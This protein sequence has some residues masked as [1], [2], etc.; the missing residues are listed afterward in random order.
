MKRLK[1]NV[2]FGILWM[3]A[4][5]ATIDWVGLTILIGLEKNLFQTKPAPLT[6][7]I[8]ATEFERKMKEKE[9]VSFLVFVNEILVDTYSSAQEL[10][11]PKVS[12]LLNKYKN[13]FSELQSGVKFANLPPN[14]M[15]DRG[16]FNYSIS[17][18][19]Q[20]TKTFFQHL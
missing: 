7:E 2:I 1:H 8:S 14:T 10:L 11:N 3:K 4:H 20:F 15:P 16:E 18:N 17:F 13:H 6:P 12:Q 19:N 9:S 5:Q